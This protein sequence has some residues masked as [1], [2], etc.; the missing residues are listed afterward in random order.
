M[1]AY[2][3]D[4]NY[5]MFHMIGKTKEENR[6]LALEFLGYPL[7]IFEADGS[8]KPSVERRLIE[9]GMLAEH[10]SV[11]ARIKTVL[12]GMANNPITRVITGFVIGWIIAELMKR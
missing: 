12:V 2:S 3:E 8:L 9:L 6:A 10:V 11:Q 4:E 7:P 5:R 1:R